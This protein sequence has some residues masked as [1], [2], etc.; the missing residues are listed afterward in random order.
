MESFVSVTNKALL[1]ITQQN[2]NKEK[3]HSLSPADIPNVESKY[4]ASFFFAIG[5]F[6]SLSLIG[7]STLSASTEQNVDLQK[8]AHTQQQALTTEVSEHSPSNIKTDQL[9]ISP[10]KKKNQH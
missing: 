2:E 8:S 6:S 9:L 4:K 3:Q 10:T 1:N 5:V 7:W